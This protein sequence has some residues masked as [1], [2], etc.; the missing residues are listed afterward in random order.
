MPGPIEVRGI[1]QQLSVALPAFHAVH[2]LRDI[3]DLL[4]QRA[5]VCPDQ[6]DGQDAN[7]ENEGEGKDPQG[8]TGTHWFAQYPRGRKRCRNDRREGPRHPGYSPQWAVV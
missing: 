2:L 7:G 6:S 5:V 8:D 3:N 1:A 4:D